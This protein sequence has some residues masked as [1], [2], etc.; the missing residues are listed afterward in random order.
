MCGDVHYWNAWNLPQSSFQVFI[1]S[2]YYKASCLLY[3]LNYTVISISSF[4]S[5]F[6]SLK[7]RIFGYSKGKPVLF[8]EFFQFGYNALRDT[9][10]YFSKQTVHTILEDIELILYRKVNKIGIE[11]N[12]IRRS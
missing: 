6:K 5:A 2:C 7:S 4:M 8:T 12:M 10:N 11:E 3:T 1:A 9:W